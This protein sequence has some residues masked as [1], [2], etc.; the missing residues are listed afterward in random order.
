MSDVYEMDCSSGSGEYSK[1]SCLMSAPGLWLCSRYA[2]IGRE[3]VA[4]RL[5]SPAGHSVGPG[6]SVPSPRLMNTPRTLKTLPY[7]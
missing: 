6:A 2:T 4:E 5:E 1:W 7:S 3:D